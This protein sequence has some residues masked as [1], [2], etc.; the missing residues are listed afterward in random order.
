[1]LLCSARLQAG[2]ADADTCPPEGGRYTNSAS[3]LP[4]CEKF[5]LEGRVNNVDES[6]AVK[7]AFTPDWIKVR[8]GLGGD[9]FF[10]RFPGGL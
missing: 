4:E 2:I 5:C 10:K 9:G 7:R 8:E 1:M 3:H 6:V